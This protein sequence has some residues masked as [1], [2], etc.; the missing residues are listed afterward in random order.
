ML[1][2][3]L[4][5]LLAI[6]A[7]YRGRSSGFVRQ[8]CS[9]I[10][11]FGGLFLGSWL[12]QHT[13][14]LVHTAGSRALVLIITIMGCALIGLTIGE[15]VG[16]RL[17]LRFFHKD[18]NKVDDVF[19]AFLSVVSLLISAWLIAAIVIGLPYDGL[20]TS[21][22][23]SRII[24]GLNKILPPAPNV[25]ASLG[26]L[27][28]PN[29]FPDVFIGD[30]PEPSQVNL[31]ALG[32]LAAAV[33]ADKASVLRIRGLGCGGIISGSG[34]VVAPGLVATNAHVVAGIAHP[35]VQDSNRSYRATAIWFDPNLD[36]AVLKVPDLPESSL[37]IAQTTFGRGTPAAVLGYPG[38][39]NFSANA[40]AIID[41]FNADGRNIYGAGHTVRDV[42]EVKA[43][44]I[45]GNSGGPLVNS[46]GQVIGI[47][48]AESTTYNHVGYALTTAQVNKE[49]KQA[50]TSSQAVSTGNCAEE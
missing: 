3:L 22:R 41:E 36:F 20:Q 5:I 30:E 39:G 32:N 18:I 4:I 9:A 11:F 26:H 38:G 13:V 7:A 17:K 48:F 28:D 14:D 8:F 24:T 23:D 10:G 16:L 37:K 21:I 34:F 47:V 42:Y 27:I 44:I 29:G 50:E 2:D 1:V 45:P 31:P 33:K 46:A 15:Y 35:Y 6:S 25:I 12:Q 40:A 49:L 19:G 43:T